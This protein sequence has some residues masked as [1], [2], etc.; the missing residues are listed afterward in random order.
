MPRMPSLFAAVGSWAMAPGAEGKG[1]QVAG[2]C[3]TTDQGPSSRGLDQQVRQADRGRAAR[4]VGARHGA[5]ARDAPFP[6]SPRQPIRL[7]EGVLFTTY[8]TLRTDER[9]EKLS[10]VRQIVEWLGADFDG[11]IIFD[12]S[13]AIAER[14]W[15]QGRASATRPPRSRGERAPAPAHAAERPRRLR[16]RDWCYHG[17]Q[18]RLRPAARVM[19]G[20]DFPFATR[21]EFVEAIEEGGV[22]GNG[23]A[24]ARPQGARSLRGALPVLRRCRIRAYRA[25]TYA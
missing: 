25:P 22:C 1:R 8:A 14:G 6:V 19:G 4:L 20:E 23:S 7:A 3:S 18:S 24:G 11:V 15:R 10:R 13:H 9:G 5:P 17:A 21:A 2:I 12:E 16:L